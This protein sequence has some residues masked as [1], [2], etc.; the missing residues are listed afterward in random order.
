MQVITPTPDHDTT[1][2][3]AVMTGLA[4]PSRGSAELSTWRVRMAP[5]TAGPE[6][7]L[8]REQ[9]W[10]LTGGSIEVTAGDRTETVVA[11]QTVVVPAGVTRRIR[12]TGESAEALVAMRAD[13]RASVP[14]SEESQPLPWAR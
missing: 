6:H 1:T 12:T 7:S 10:T 5:E 9:V 13:G 14:G 8:D 2:P 11:G 3:A 4:A